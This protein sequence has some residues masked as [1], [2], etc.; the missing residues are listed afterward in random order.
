MDSYRA[1][2]LATQG[3]GKEPELVSYRFATDGRHFVSSGAP[4]IGYSAGEEHLAH[5]VLESI[6]IDMMADSLRGHFY[7]L[8][9]F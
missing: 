2:S 9:D 7:L 5:T 1:L 6:S 3:M 8:R 4:I